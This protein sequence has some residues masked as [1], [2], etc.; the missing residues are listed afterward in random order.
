M[1]I[2][3]IAEPEI[4]PITLEEAKQH[5]RIDIDYDDNLINVYITT[6]RRFCEKWCALSFITQ[7]KSIFYNINDLN[8]T[9][10]NYIKLPMNPVQTIESYTT[11]DSDGIGSIV[12]PTDYYLAGQNLV[13]S[14]SYNY[15]SDMRSQNSY[16]IDAV[17]GFGDDAASVPEEIKTAIKYLVAHYY[18]NREALT[19]DSV[20][21][22]SNIAIPFN[23]T[24]G[25]APY[26]EFYL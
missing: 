16:Q 21:P 11:F 15:P 4:E 22:T 2:I 7:T 24:A 1:R 9:W 26:K 18:Q 20:N 3:T 17:V 23:I 13:F 12:D 5:A 6:A 14:S 25:L 10:C 8:F 19:N